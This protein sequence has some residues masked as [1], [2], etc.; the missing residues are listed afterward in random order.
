MNLVKL[1]GKINTFISL[2]IVTVAMGLGFHLASCTSQQGDSSDTQVAAQDEGQ[3]VDSLDLAP[4]VHFKFCGA[5]SDCDKNI[6]WGGD[7]AFAY[8]KNQQPREVSCGQVK[9][10]DT[11]G[12]WHR[13]TC[14]QQCG[15][16]SD[17]AT[18]A[19][20]LGQCPENNEAAHNEAWHNAVSS[21][22][23]RKP[24]V[25]ADCPSIDQVCNGPTGGVSGAIV[26]NRTDLKASENPDGLPVTNKYLRQVND[27][28]EYIATKN[29]DG[30]FTSTGEIVTLNE[31]CDDFVYYCAATWCPS[32]TTRVANDDTKEYYCKADLAQ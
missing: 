4:G 12:V 18:K 3:I 32:T 1:Q 23:I 14:P 5:D 9:I 27:E 16:G 29:E 7:K 20:I 10:D 25:P 22:V 24:S 15:A 8:C 21:V 31:R 19:C 26:T 6:Q 17:G 11:N 13:L 2:G 30:A 28:G